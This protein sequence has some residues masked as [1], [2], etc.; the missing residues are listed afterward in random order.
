MRPILSPPKPIGSCL[1][2]GCTIRLARA[3]D[4]FL[5]SPFPWYTARVRDA[6]KEV[7]KEFHELD[8]AYLVRVPALQDR[9]RV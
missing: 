7:L 1:T 8:Q 9:G 6:L 2:W 4:E 3:R 5:S